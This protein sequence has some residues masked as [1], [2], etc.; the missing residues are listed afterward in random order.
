MSGV[1]DYISLTQRSLDIISSGLSRLNAVKQQMQAINPAASDAQQQLDSL[2]AQY[3]SIRSELNP[4][5]AALNTQR[6]S[7]WG[8]LSEAQRTEVNAS[9]QVQ[10]ASTATQLT[11]A[12]KAEHQVILDNKTAEIKAAAQATATPTPTETV[13]GAQT[14][15][16][17][18]QPGLTG[19]ASDDSGAV[20]NNPV[21]APNNPTATPVVPATGAT[22][23]GE[24]NA[25]S[26]AYQFQSS[27]ISTQAVNNASQPGKRL[28][29]PLGEFASYT[30]QI[31]LYMITADAYDAFV[32]SGRR[33]I[34][35]LNTTSTA[36]TQGGAFLIA[37]SGGVNKTT[38]KRAP[39]FDF[40]YGIDNL[41]MKTRL[42]GRATQ[43]ATNIFEFSFN[44]IEPYGFSFLSNLRK[45]S[46][47]IQ[48][49][50]GELR[51]QSGVQNP[52]RQTF[53]LGIRFFGY[54]A[55]GRP[56]KPNIKMSDNTGVID[57][58]SQSGELFQH[59]YDI[60]INEMKFKV[61]GKSITY[62][63]KAA[64]SS[65]Q[66][67]FNVT[68][69]FIQTD[70]NITASTVGIAIDKLIT[71][72]NTEQERLA[73]GT[74]PSLKYPTKY[75]IVW[76][77]NTGDILGASIVSPA[78]LD[79]SRWAPNPIQTTAESNAASESATQTASPEEINITVSG[80]QPIVQAINQIIMQS[81]Y[82]ET[83]LNVIYTADLQADPT[84][85]AQLL[86][87]PEYQK[88]TVSWY[89]CTPQITEI[90]WDDMIRDWSYKISY[91]IGRYDTPVVDSPMVQANTIYPGPHKRYE[92]WYTGKNTEIV[93]YEQ[94]LNNAYIQTVVS[95]G[96]TS[97][98]QESGAV[99]PT[100]NGNAAP[101][102]SSTNN[103]PAP[104]TPTP[105]APN[106]VTNQ[107]R[108]GTTGY[109]FEAQNNYLTALYDP[110]ALA[111]AKITILGDPDFLQEEQSYSEELIYDKYYG[112]NEFSINPAGGQIFIE[113]D[114]KEGVDYGV[115]TGLM[116]INDKILFWQY[117]PEVSIKGISYKVHT[118]TSTFQNGS[119]KQL[120][121]CNI[122]SFANTEEIV[123]A[124]N[125]ASS[126]AASRAQ[127][128][129]N[130]TNARLGIT[131]TG[132]SPNN[133]SSTAAT[134]SG[135]RQDQPVTAVTPNNTSNTASRTTAQPTVNTPQGPVASED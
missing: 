50:Q 115:S 75:E 47:A 6:T 85:K 78:R 84:L 69:G 14:P 118:V 102:A 56:M 33:N 103:N 21:V 45:A 26:G 107:P 31:S 15:T 54:D 59:F 72:L 66:R 108:L 109:G 41:V 25:N 46:D 36:A 83:A 64:S 30:Y 29:N 80:Q 55:S 20:T 119:F 39:G 34:N 81:S 98:A 67:G 113:I 125:A 114:F 3:Q 135:T 58:L 77:P 76:L 91:L 40:D 117:P 132:N 52:T 53:I 95:A 134:T 89:N 16:G 63:C 100:A 105:L 48:E 123:S 131:N 49:Y 129:Q 9:P 79:K 27:I 44:I 38:S 42:T 19:T 70:K 37:Q 61:T 43:S 18:T 51:S 71:Q 8:T 99:P 106:M 116:S 121:E 94:E 87:R 5:L 104:A 101:A 65:I 11:N 60:V 120:L 23:G 128:Q 122:N 17:N 24:T 32:A 92:Y 12:N 57:P 62:A 22:A 133:S 88:K 2:E 73:T 90:K 86:Q 126:E 82:L 112:N 28:K 74:P 68:R 93:S 111:T 97:A 7:I 110:S 35:V 96:N 127:T 10:Q 130:E 13:A 4:Q 1:S 124:A